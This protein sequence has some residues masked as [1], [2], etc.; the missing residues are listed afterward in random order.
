[1]KL[2]TTELKALIESV[3]AKRNWTQ[4][5]L[6]Q[7]LNIGPE[8]VSRWKT[9]TRIHKGHYDELIRL[10]TDQEPQSV[11]VANAP[12]KIPFSVT[13]PKGSIRVTTDKN[14]DINITGIMLAMLDKKE[15]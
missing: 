5:R 6:S 1:M 10:N 12:L 3:L 13:I 11:D 4:D 8:M 7:E 9:G 15:T 14:G 2:P